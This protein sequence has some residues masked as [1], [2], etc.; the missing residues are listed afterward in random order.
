[1]SQVNTALGA[2]GIDLPA[3]QTDSWVA[4]GV[5]YG[6]YYTFY[7]WPLS[8]PPWDKNLQVTRIAYDSD[9]NGNRTVQVDVRNTSASDYASYGLFVLWTS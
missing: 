8:G 2:T 5:N 7:A 4:S 1:M 6:Q 9:A 3:G